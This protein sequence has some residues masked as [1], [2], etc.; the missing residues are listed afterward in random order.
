MMIR[1]Y[2]FSAKVDYEPIQVE[3]LLKKIRDASCHMVC[4]NLQYAKYHG[5]NI[6]IEIWGDSSVFV[7]GR[8]KKEADDLAKQMEEEITTLIAKNDN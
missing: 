7:W 5:Q 3:S 6:K 4:Q 1:R 8:T 2:E